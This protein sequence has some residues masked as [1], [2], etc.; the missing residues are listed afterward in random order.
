MSGRE[1]PKTSTKETP[2]SVD[3]FEFKPGDVS[4][5]TDWHVLEPGL[6]YGEFK[7]DGS[8]TTITAV[9]IDPRRFDFVLCSA[10]KDKGTPHTLGE[11]SNIYKLSAAI[12]ASMY[13]KDG[14]TSTGYMRDGDY[15]NNNRI[16]Q[17]FGAFLIAGPDAQDLPQAAIIDRDTDGWQELL[18][19]YRMVVQNYRI[20]SAQRRILW[21]PGGPHYSISAIAQDGEGQILFLH[22]RDRIEAY[23]FAQQ[24]L[25][26]PLNIR[27]VMY[28]EGGGQAGLL[29]RSDSLRQELQGRNA[30]DFFV[31]GN[32]AVTLPNVIGVRRRTNSSRMK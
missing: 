12:N 4:A 16:V 14:Y 13:L 22:S 8:E 9:R 18:G 17:R 11:W 21:S 24:L 28:V 7:D 31:T 2:P 25:H 6:G 10:D 26:L 23:A 30:V 20:I 27:T 1:E 5:D 3:S 15:I 19:H 32:M 29:V